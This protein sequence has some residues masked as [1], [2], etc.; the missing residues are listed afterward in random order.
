MFAAAGGIF[1]AKT[2]RLS[3]LAQALPE[4]ALALA[5]VSAGYPEI[6]IPIVLGSS[7]ALV[8]LAAG[9]AA[10]AAKKLAVRE[11]C[12]RIDAPLFAAALAIFY[13]CAR[14]GQVVFG[15]GVFLVLSFLAVLPLVLRSRPEEF[16]PRDLISPGFLFSGRRIFQVVAERFDYDAALVRKNVYKSFLAALASVFILAFSA[17]F[18]VESLVNIDAIIMF[19]AAVLSVSILAVALALPEILTSVKNIRQNRY[20]PVLG[21]VFAGALINILLICGVAA[22]FS[23][24]SA[25]G[26]VLNLGLPFLIVAAVLLTLSSFSRKIIIE[27]GWL[28]VI[29]YILFLVKLFGL[30]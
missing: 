27:Q 13:F 17:G 11:D 21:N 25:D 14:D 1:G 24:L 3:L 15:E 18:V 2:A 20:E 28:Y 12:S 22:I 19:P 5:A 4:L 23:P 16:G 7:L 30:F 26:L 8:L 10:I 29:L 6:V 9:I